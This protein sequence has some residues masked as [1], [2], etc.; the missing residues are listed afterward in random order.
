MSKKTKDQLIR[1]WEK[2]ATQWRDYSRNLLS[3]LR[4][5]RERHR[6]VAMGLV[7]SD[8]PEKWDDK[9]K[10]QK[11]SADYLLDAEVPKEPEGYFY[12]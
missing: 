4:V 6:S 8:A 3:E 12:P 11:I 5:A 1:H 9:T 2:R 10:T 7:S